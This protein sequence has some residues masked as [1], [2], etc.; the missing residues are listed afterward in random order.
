MTLGVLQCQLYTLSVVCVGDCDY[1]DIGTVKTDGEGPTTVSVVTLND[2]I[3]LE[4][5]DQVLLKF[6]AVHKDMFIEELEKAGEFLR[7]TSY[8]NILDDDSNQIFLHLSLFLLL[9]LY[10]LL[11]TPLILT[12]HLQIWR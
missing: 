10:G 3:A 7:N 5:H 2:D 8:L 11:S 4:Y 9:L 6:K 1:V 12:F